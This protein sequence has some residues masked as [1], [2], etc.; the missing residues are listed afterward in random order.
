M[1]KFLFVIVQ[2]LLTAMLMFGSTTLHA[3]TESPE[4]P[5]EK[6]AQAARPFL[7]TWDGVSCDSRQHPNG[8]IEPY[9][10]RFNIR[11]D[12]VP[13]QDKGTRLAPV[14]QLLA[15]QDKSG[16]VVPAKPIDFQTVGFYQ[17]P[18][19]SEN[20]GHVVFLSANPNLLV[21]LSLAEN[22]DSGTG[23]N[24]VHGLEGQVR[25]FLDGTQFPL[26]A[27]KASDTPAKDQWA[28][29]E[30]LSMLCP[31]TNNDDNDGQNIASLQRISFSTDDTDGDIEAALKEFNTFADEHSDVIDFAALGREDVGKPWFAR[32]Y[33]FNDKGDPTTWE[34]E[35]FPRILD[36]VVAIERDFIVHP[37]GHS[38]RYGE[39]EL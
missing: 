7:G 1:K 26:Y 14:F 25:I 31:K 24:I 9:G 34:E 21:A 20:S 27:I 29:V 39:S 28:Y 11:V 8:E 38:G 37:E 16:Q 32:F 5:Q 17:I 12:S 30:A 3:Q 15:V 35:G 4:I 2:V 23:P 18:S 10:L 6:V 36:V 13:D 22:S 33:H 19:E